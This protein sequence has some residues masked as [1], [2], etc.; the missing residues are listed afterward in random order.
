[1]SAEV[2]TSSSVSLRG[3]AEITQEPSQSSSSSELLIM[4]TLDSVIPPQPGLVEP[5]MNK[6]RDRSPSER[7]DGRS[8][9]SQRKP[10][11]RSRKPISR[12]RKPL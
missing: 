7:S 9:N 3:E 1:M 10:L 2:D 6:R 8:S 4:D 5:R 11:S 12:S